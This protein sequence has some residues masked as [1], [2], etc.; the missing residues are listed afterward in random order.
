MRVRVVA[1]SDNYTRSL[2]LMD[3]YSRKLKIETYGLF[4]DAVTYDKVRYIEWW[5]FVRNS[6]RSSRGIIWNWNFTIVSTR[7]LAFDLWGYWLR[8]PHEDCWLLLNVWWRCTLCPRA[9]I[10]LPV[11]FARLRGRLYLL[12]SW[13]LSAWHTLRLCRSTTAWRH[14]V[15]RENEFLLLGESLTD[16]LLDTRLNEYLWEESLSNLDKRLNES[17]WGE[18][19]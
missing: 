3:W 19:L 17:I 13:F 10:V 14:L 12:F 5:S 4:I 15:P 8:R 7:G 16:W 18:S 11:N 2:Y 1:F 9:P 6:W